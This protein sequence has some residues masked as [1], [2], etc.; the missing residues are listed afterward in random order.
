M[1]KHLSIIFL[2]AVFCEKAQVLYSERFNSLALTSYTSG[3]V[4]CQYTNA[5][6]NLSLIQD[7]NA[8]NVGSLNN[9]NIPF[10]VPSLKNA[11]WTTLYNAAEQDTFLVCTSWFDSTTF[12]ADR[13]FI[14]PSV[15]VGP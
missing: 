1:K 8:N 2:L 5:P 3:T 11:G 9:P 13:W 7:G 12:V 6:S 4:I 15:T 10:H 14:T